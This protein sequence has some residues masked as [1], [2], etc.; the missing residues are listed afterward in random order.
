MIR[1]TDEAVKNQLQD[2]QDYIAKDNPKVANKVVNDIFD[3]V[4]ILTMMPEVGYKYQNQDH[5]RIL[6]SG[7]YRIA[8]F[9]K[10]SKDI[11]ILGV[12][13]RSLDI[14]RYLKI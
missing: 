13:H 1:W 5:I 6:L 9:I 12:F 4:Q 8:Y 3:K 7:H 14:E 10:E 11:D 2:I